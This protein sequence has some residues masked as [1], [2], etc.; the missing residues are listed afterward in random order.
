MVQSQKIKSIK[1]LPQWFNI[2]K[3]EE[4]G[5]MDAAGWC[6]NLMRRQSLDYIYHHYKFDDY[7][8]HYDMWNPDIEAD[9][10]LSWKEHSRASALAHKYDSIK[11]ARFATV[12]NA[13]LALK[14][15]LCESTDKSFRRLQEFY[16]GDSDL[17]AGIFSNPELPEWF[18]DPLIFD[19][20][21]TAFFIVDLCA[22]DGLIQKQIN[23]A[24]SQARKA[25]G[26]KIRKQCFTD[27]TFEKWHE[28]SILPFCDLRNWA[29]Y[30]KV[31]ITNSAI[32]Q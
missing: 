23:D 12:I 22:P 26:I 21:Q 24:L 1:D 30:N 13:Y 16:Q 6:I 29:R 20:N 3:Y 7:I 31:E 27:N 32:A 4:A 28:F 8:Y 2:N 11:A 9:P 18:D 5:Q 10:L 17:R 14:D 25:R 19:N 15:T